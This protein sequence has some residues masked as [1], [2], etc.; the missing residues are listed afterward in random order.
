[1]HHHALIS[2]VEGAK[3]REGGSGVT[4]IHLAPQN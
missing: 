3:P 4:V 1:L 2:K